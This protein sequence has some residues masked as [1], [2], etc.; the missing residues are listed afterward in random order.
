MDKTTKLLIRLAASAV[1]LLAIGTPTYLIISNNL[2]E[3]AEQKREKNEKLTSL[4][5]VMKQVASRLDNGVSLSSSTDAFRPL[6]DELAIAKEFHP[7][8]PAVIAALKAESLFNILQTYWYNS[9]YYKG[10]ALGL[11]PEISKFN[12]IAGKQVA[13]PLTTTRWGGVNETE[14]KV[15]RA[16]MYYHISS[17]L[18]L[19]AK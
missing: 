4:K 18:K 8:D 7:D 10:V 15:Q 14:A 5:N 16:L 12:R 1:I 19:G 3:I 2:N 9:I 17:V 11:N 6:V 13:T